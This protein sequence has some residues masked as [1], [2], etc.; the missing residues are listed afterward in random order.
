MHLARHVD[1]SLEAVQEILTALLDISRLDAKALMPEITQFRIDEILNQLRVEFGPVAQEKGLK[2]VFV[3]CS[4]TVRSDRRLLR[5]LVQNLI[6]NA[7]KYTPRGKILVGVRRKAKVLS[8]YVYDTGIGIP[9]DKQRDIFREFERLAPAVKTARGVGLG[10]SIVER[11]SRVLGHAIAL[12]SEPGRGSVFSVEIARGGSSAPAPETQAELQ[13]I[14][15]AWLNGMKVAVIDNEPDVLRGMT[16]LLGDWGCQCFAGADLAEVLA[17]L[18]TQDAAPDAVIADFHLDSD[19]G[20]SAV[21]MLRR[22]FGPHLPAIL[23]TADH[24]QS[25]SERAANL[26]IRVLNKPLRPASL[27]ALLTQWHVLE[28]VAD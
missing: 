8:L 5:R 9:G 1:A 6:S 28:S 20:I 23:A 24:S 16:I 15:P 18:E 21:T 13:S 7:I 27:R 17:Q 14:S 3:P 11:L 4:L 19:D 10:L 12:D 22:R 26:N 25:I 2:L